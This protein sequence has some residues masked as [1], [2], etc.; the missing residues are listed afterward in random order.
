MKEFKLFN[1]IE[2]IKL[3]EIEPKKYNYKLSLL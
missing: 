2:N 3:E 1:N